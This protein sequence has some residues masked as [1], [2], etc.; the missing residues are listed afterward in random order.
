MAVITVSVERKLF[1]LKT[2]YS[3]MWALCCGS[4][5]KSNEQIKLFYYH[6]KLYNV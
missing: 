6:P 1:V 5:I 4:L 3:N 2:Y